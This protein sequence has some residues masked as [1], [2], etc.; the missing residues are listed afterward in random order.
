MAPLH[1]GN[2]INLALLGLIIGVTYYVGIILYNI[3][4]HPLRS[5]PG[6]LSHK[7]S[8]VPGVYHNYHGTLP[9]HITSLHARY[10][11][12]VRISPNELAFADPQAWKDIYGHRHNGQEEMTKD[13][14][15]YRIEP[16]MPRNI[17]TAPREEH[18]MLRRQL[19]HGFS[20]RS[21]RG[22]EPIIGSYV[23]L[24][25][26]RLNENCNGGAE[27]LN[28]REWL[29]WTT[30]DVIGDLCFGT[31]FGCLEKTDYHPWVKLITGSIRESSYVRSIKIL[32]FGR[33][34][35]WL[36]R[37]AG[38]AGSQHRALALEKTK[39][40]KALG[41]ERPDFMEGLLQKEKE[42]TID[43]PKLAI[44]ASDLILAGS[45]TTATLL[46]G[47]LYFL[48]MHPDKL[49]RLVEEVR[50]TF[51]TDEEISLSS[52]GSLTYMLACLNESLRLYPPVPFGLPRVVP[53]GGAT[54]AGT[55]VPEGTPVAVWQWAVNHDSRFWT[56]PYRFAPERFMGD[57][58]FKGDRLDA[59]QPFSYGPRNCIGKNLAYAEMRLIL[60]KIVFNFD[61]NIDDSS[62]TWLEDNKAHVLWDKPSLNVHLTPV[63]R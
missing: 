28:M 43:V 2:S 39:Q 59:M 49:Q 38:A 58:A 57:A 25:I 41:A 62:R 14:N 30:F 12:V 3:F 22:Q 5:F 18:S 55:F 44:T 19:A 6:P 46:S 1:P 37:R 23:D 48:T 42:G 52:V 24:L 56:D 17:I 10:G 34:A 20:E 26:R 32:G 21:M 8:R 29:N 16:S 33:L 35:A 60:A 13:D 4:L 36:V 51:K 7:I 40:R 45:E 61:M 15:F 27:A 11:P 63:K 31:P 50:G 53:K 47:A 54:I 9:Y